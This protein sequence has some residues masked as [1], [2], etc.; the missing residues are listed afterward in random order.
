M[1][2]EQTVKPRRWK[3]WLRRA[4]VGLCAVFVLLASLLA[5]G[6]FVPSI[7]WIGVLGSLAMT[8]WPG[9]FIVGPL[10]A[11]LLVWTLSRGRLRIGVAALAALTMLGAGILI[12]QVV[13]V[14]HANDVDVTIGNAFG[15]SQSL[16]TVQPDEIVTYVRDQGDDLTLRIFKPRGKAPATGWPVLMHIHGGGWVEGSN[17]EQS[18]DM[19]WYADKGWVVISVGYSLSSTKRHLWDKVMPQLGCAMAW[20][21]KNIGARGGD[22][23]RLSLRGGSA[24]GNLTANAAF[25]ANAGTLTSVC[26]GTI[27][28]VRSVT[29]IYPGADLVAIYNNDYVPNGPDVKTMVTR[30][31]GGTPVQYPERYRAV[32]SATHLTKAAPPTLI[33]ITENDHLVPLASMQKFAADVRKAGVPVRTVSIPF[34]EHGFDISGLGNAIVRQVSL[35]WMRKYDKVPGEAAATPTESA[36][37]D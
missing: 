6:A 27:P 1:M 28:R 31:T 7:T 23:T 33:F 5:L 14:A 32:A 8:I 2:T 16:E 20:T 29:P 37:V 4:F 35:E 15:F 17:D 30:Y 26:G 18:A 3:T 19:R 13:S 11:A 12:A 25:M 9:W 10:A 24:G 34:G 36:P 21:E 22:V